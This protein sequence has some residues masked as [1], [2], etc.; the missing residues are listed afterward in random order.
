M[1]SKFLLILLI[2]I[3]LSIS[4]CRILEVFDGIKPTAQETQNL[5]QISQLNSKDFIN[6]TDSAFYKIKEEQILEMIKDTS[7]AYKLKPTVMC[8]LAWHESD[9][10]K[11]AHRKIKDSNGRWSYGL[12]MIQMETAL[13]IDKEAIESKLLTPAY[14]ASIAHRI[15][16]RNLAKYGTYQYAIAAH[17]AGTIKNGKITNSDFV[18]LVYVSIG[19]IVSKNDF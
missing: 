9:K 2:A 19:E 12:Y 5:P 7:N 10:F 3:L 8:G 11:F 13:S 14:N 1:K 6:M 18:K 15:F 17:N 4:G 16:Q